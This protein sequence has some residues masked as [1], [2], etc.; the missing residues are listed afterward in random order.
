VRGA[1]SDATSLKATTCRIIFVK[2]GGGVYYY[3]QLKYPVKFNTE[4]AVHVDTLLCNRY[5]DISHLAAFSYIE[6]F[7]KLIKHEAPEPF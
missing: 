5:K 4:F 1:V 7:S 3:I 6:H 2:G